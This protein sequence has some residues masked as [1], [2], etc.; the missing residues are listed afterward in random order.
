MISIQR[1]RPGFLPGLL[2]MVVGAGLVGIAAT[3]HAQVLGACGTP[4]ENESAAE[5]PEGTAGTAVSAMPLPGERAV[6]FELP[7]VVGDEL[8]MVKLSDYN[9]K[10][11]M[12]C[13][14]PADFTFV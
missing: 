13:F 2:C 9:G 14:Y 11:R 12:V 8:M 1:W 10:W 3:S 4:T 6:N 5:A 7:A